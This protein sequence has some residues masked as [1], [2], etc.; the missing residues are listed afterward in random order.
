MVSVGYVATSVKSGFLRV[1]KKT[2]GFPH[3]P[4]S[5]RRG[6]RSETFGKKK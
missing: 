5:S 6:K 3:N 1:L 4:L 2:A